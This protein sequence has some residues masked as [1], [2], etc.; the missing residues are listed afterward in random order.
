MMRRTGLQICRLAL[1]PLVAGILLLGRLPCPLLE[2]EEARYAEI[3]RQMLATGHYITPVL[4]GQPYYQKPPLLYWLVMASYSIF[5]VHDWAARLIPCAAALGIVALTWGWAQR[6]SGGRSGRISSLVLCLSPAFIYRS[7]LLSMDTVLALWVLAALA[8]AH[9]AL[10]GLALQRR[11]WLCA[12]VAC[13]LGVL[14][15]GPVALL[16]VSTPIAVLRLLNS[17]CPRVSGRAWL[18]F[19][20]VVVLVAGPWFAT[21]AARDPDAA[22]AFFWMHNV[23]RFV[24]PFDHVKP[25]WYFLPELL[26]G[27]LPWTL[28]LVPLMR[29]WMRSKPMLVTR[30]VTPAVS[31]LVPLALVWCVLFFSLSGCKRP[32]YILPALPLL[33]MVLGGYLAKNPAR[34]LPALGGA[35]FALLLAG[36]VFCLPT[37]HRKFSLR[38][39][40]AGQR[41]LARTLPVACYPRRW[42]SISFYL[43][44]EPV[45]LYARAEEALL[46]R[47]LEERGECL[48]FVKAAYLD[49]LRAALPETLEF[50]PRAPQGGNVIPTVLRT[51]RQKH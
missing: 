19:L 27:M 32:A 41:A 4:H 50:Q 12:G 26:A 10:S 16:L 13:G 51:R 22:A 30:S 18:G 3:P 47:D 25:V 40:V 48:I 23:Q 38:E 11:W 28:W 37:Y 33:A 6:R 39:Q 7:P 9:Q 49:D 17:S 15:K 8:A 45:R 5:G 2:P 21:I 42:D 44:R 24:A 34:S 20:G 35:A 29:E 43:E 14:T 1:V 31:T 36:V 46:C